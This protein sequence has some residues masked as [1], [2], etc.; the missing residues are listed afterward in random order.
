MPREE[1]C[2][3]RDDNCH[4]ILHHKWGGGV[5]KYWY[6]FLILLLDGFA[7]H[8]TMTANARM[9][10]WGMQPRA[11]ERLLRGLRSAGSTGG[12]IHTVIIKSWYS[13]ACE[14]T[15]VLFYHSFNHTL[16]LLHTSL[17]LLSCSPGRHGFEMCS[18]YSFIVFPCGEGDYT[19]SIRACTEVECRCALFGI[20]GTCCLAA[21]M[22]VSS[23]IKVTS[24]LLYEA[25][26]FIHASSNHTVLQVQRPLAGHC[27][28]LQETQ[29]VLELASKIVTLCYNFQSLQHLVCIA[30]SSVSESLEGIMNPPCVHSMIWL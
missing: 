15:Q 3:E 11:M 24:L 27:L 9:T 14:L 7:V 19:A 20:L 5:V 12:H 25:R 4:L 13:H 29:W 17:Q 6:Q 1:T 2:R 16:K 26:V 28:W 18:P 23:L 8:T 10:R 22:P 21:K 30:P